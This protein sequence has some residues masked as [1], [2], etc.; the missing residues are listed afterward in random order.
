M[1]AYR[2]GFPG[3]RLAARLGLPLRVVVNVM[4]DMEARVFVASCED[5]LPYL[6]IATEGETFA[7]LKKN[8]RDCI[9]DAFEESFKSYRS[10]ELDCSFKL[11]EAVA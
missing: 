11:V 10:N 2:V 4:Y 8:V 3:W 9:A 7:E 1:F 5:F 6:G